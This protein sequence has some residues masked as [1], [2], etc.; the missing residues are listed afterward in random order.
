MPPFMVAPKHIK[1]TVNKSACIVARRTV[2]TRRPITSA[3]RDIGEAKKRSKNPDSMS[4]ATSVPAEVE[5]NIT[6]CKIVAAN[7]NAT[8]DDTS[9]NPGIARVLSNAALLKAVKN[10]GKARDGTQACG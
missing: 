10:S 3:K 8:N 1:I 9:G 7:K 5:P 2:P 6:P 4:I